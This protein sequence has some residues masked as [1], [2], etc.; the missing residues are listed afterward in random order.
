MGIAA[1][2]SAPLP[3]SPH[4][5]FSSCSS[6]FTLHTIHPHFSSNTDHARPRHRL[7]S[8]RNCA[9]HDHARQRVMQARSPARCVR[10]DLDVTDSRAPLACL[11]RFEELAACVVLKCSDDCILYDCFCFV[12]FFLVPTRRSPAGRYKRGETQG[13]EWTGLLSVNG[14][15]EEREEEERCGARRSGR[16]G[17]RDGFD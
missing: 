12:A 16:R 1:C 8:Q 9:C 14:E 13:G 3:P 11:S 5:H 10:L 7:R 15:R 17:G 2:L 6:D 4:Q